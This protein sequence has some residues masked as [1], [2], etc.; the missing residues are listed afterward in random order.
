MLIAESLPP[1]T[2][3]A[4]GE[5]ESAVEGPYNPIET[6]IVVARL[7]GAEPLA[8]VGERMDTCTPQLSGLAAVRSGYGLCLY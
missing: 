4:L 5:G 2:L 6:W 8:L 1:V 7:S 3:H